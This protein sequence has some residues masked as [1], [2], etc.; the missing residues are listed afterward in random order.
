MSSILLIK[1]SKNKHPSCRASLSSVKIF[2]NLYSSE[3]MPLTRFKLLKSWFF[4]SYSTSCNSRWYLNGRNDMSG[5]SPAI[6]R[7]YLKCKIMWG[8]GE[9][10]ESSSFLGPI[11]LEWTKTHLASAASIFVG[12]EPSWT[13]NNLS[14]KLYPY[15]WKGFDL[16]TA[17]KLSCS[18]N[19]YS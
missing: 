11:C 6:I 7:M 8:D 9:G 18:A 15:D 13:L 19:S 10:K 4:R 1:P 5:L 2:S 16:I 3:Q 14:S 17:R 12:S